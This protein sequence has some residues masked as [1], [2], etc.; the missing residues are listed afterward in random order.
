MHIN[1]VFRIALH[2]FQGVSFVQQFQPAADI[3][4]LG[5]IAVPDGTG[6]AEKEFSFLHPEGQMDVVF[7][8]RT[9]ALIDKM[10]D[11]RDKKQGRDQR[12]IDRSCFRDRKTQ[13]RVQHLFQIQE[14][15][16]ESKIGRQ[17]YFLPAA[18]VEL[19]AE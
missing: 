6:T 16:E 1:P 15:F 19:I 8:L 3:V 18:I 10:F 5:H 17:E 14:V 9:F 11:E 4:E 12:E 2:F 7:F 13:H